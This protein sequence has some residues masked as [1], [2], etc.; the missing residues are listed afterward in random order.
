MDDDILLS[1]L[2]ISS[3]SY[4]LK[5]SKY[6]NRIC[7]SINDILDAIYGGIDIGTLR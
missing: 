3:I 4:P 5:A 2:K 7:S 1:K 6:Q